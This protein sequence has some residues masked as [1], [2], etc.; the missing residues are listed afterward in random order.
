MDRNIVLEFVRVTEAAAICA[1]KWMGKGDKLRADQAAVDA[2]R[3]RFNSIDFRGR[4]VIGEG[5]KDEAP[6]LFDGE[7][8]GSG[9]G[10][11]IDLAVDPLE[12]TANLSQGKPNAI[13]V[14]AAGPKGSL[15]DAPG[16]YADQLAV[17][18]EARGAI[19]IR[20]PVGENLVSVSKALGK[21]VDE[22]T[23]MILERPR[24]EQMI[25]DVREAGA[26]IRLI[27]H[28]T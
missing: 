21:K 25:K 28:G 3:R 18:K 23:V 10:M 27:E 7:E 19:D 11:E 6:M 1:S 22:L 16:S 9:S 20:R 17:G 12:C 14:L 13:S 15:L 24:H 8:L 26:R 4:V 5:E 2:M